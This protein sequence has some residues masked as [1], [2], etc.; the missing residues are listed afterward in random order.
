[1]KFVFG[2]FNKSLGGQHSVFQSQDMRFRTVSVN[3]L[4]I[5]QTIGKDFLGFA[6]NTRHLHPGFRQSAGFI[7][8]NNRSTAQSFGGNHFSDQSS[9]FQNPL[10]ANRQNNGDGYRQSFRDSRHGHG[11]GRQKHFKNF[12]TS[13]YSQNENEKRKKNY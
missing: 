10:H 9:L 5:F 11:H 8:A 1:M 4:R 2:I 12:P 7:G 3:F 6:E 13:R